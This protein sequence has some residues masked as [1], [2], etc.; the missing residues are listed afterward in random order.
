MA[1][2]YKEVWTGEL[3]KQFSRAEQAEFLEGLPD[4]SQYVDNDV[5]HL[6]ELGVDPDVLINN[7]TYPIPLQE[8]EDEDIA[9]SLDKYQTKRTRITD[10]ELYAC[11]YNKIKRHKEAHGNAISEN[12]H[13]KAIHALAPSSNATKTPVIATTG[14]DDGTG[15]KRMVRADILTLKEKADK[16]G[17]PKKNRRLVLCSDHVN[18]LLLED[19]EFRAKYMDHEEGKISRMYGFDMYEYLNNPMY[20]SDG[21]KCSFGAEE[22]DGDTEASVFFYTKRCF[23]AKGTTKMYWKKAENDP[24]NQ[25]NQINFRHRFLVMPTKNDAQG[26]I[27]SGAVEEEEE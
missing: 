22:A 25:E 21:E 6:V 3:V 27:Y 1:D 10:D 19:K 7:T 12:K 23:K 20:S 2:V 17:I 8:I 16:A 18:D 4:F 15:R 14:D 11:T 5:I 24:E 9:I 13:D 26:A